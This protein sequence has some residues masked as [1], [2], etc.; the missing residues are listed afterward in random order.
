MR[1]FSLD[2]MT[3]L[4]E[5]AETGAELVA[6]CRVLAGHTADDSRGPSWSMGALALA[7]WIMDA[8]KR[9]DLQRGLSSPVQ[10]ADRLET[11]L[12]CNDFGLDAEREAEFL[13]DVSKMTSGAVMSAMFQVAIPVPAQILEDLAGLETI[14]AQHAAGAL[15]LGGHLCSGRLGDHLPSGPL[16]HAVAD[17]RSPNDFLLTGMGFAFRLSLSAA[18][19]MREALDAG[20]RHC[21]SAG[22]DQS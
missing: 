12:A 6:C 21:R 16:F 18:T 13:H 17:D 1:R 22:A 8:P 19:A 9:L 15:P 4:D 10:F 3:W 20:I 2:G 5:P 7:D 11:L 14:A